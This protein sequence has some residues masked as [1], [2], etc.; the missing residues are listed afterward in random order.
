MNNQ[1]IMDHTM[2]QWL[3]IN[4]QLTEMIETKHICV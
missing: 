2:P 4:Q 1:F 3:I